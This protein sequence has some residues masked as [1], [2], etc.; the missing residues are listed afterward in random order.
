MTTLE[1]GHAP[2]AT[3]RHM[4][5]LKGAADFMKAQ[6]VTR[7]GIVN[8]TKQQSIAEHSF[9]VWVLVKEWGP[10]VLTDNELLCAKELALTHDLAEIR[11][12]DAPTPH[13]TPEVKAH[14]DK[15]EQEIYQQIPV[16]DRVKQ[17]VKFC[18][19]AESVL[20]LKLYGQGRHA[21]E[22]RELLAVQMWKRLTTSLFN[23]DERLTLHDQ[24]NE[25]FHDT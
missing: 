10:H 1:T 4:G 2:P 12:G 15:V 23:M 20:F 11:T 21:E 25:A 22:V 14:L 13:K 6:Y 19:T 24:F 16:S 7:W 17:L 5:A 8:T 9:L 3:G 18:D